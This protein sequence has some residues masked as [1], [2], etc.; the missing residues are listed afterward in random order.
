MG[1]TS[2]GPAVAGASDS[3]G[4]AADDSRVTRDIWLLAGVIVVGAF[5][6]T[7]T[8]TIVN[9]ALGT[10]SAEL[11]ASMNAVQLVATGYLIAL[12][13]AIPLSGWA[14][15]RIGADR[16]WL[17]ALAVFTL[18]SAA[19]AAAGSIHLLIGLR[20]LQGLAG[21]LLVPTGQM[22]L[23]AAA[24]P[25]RMGRVMSIVGIPVVLAPVLGPSLGA[26]LLQH[27][28]WQWLFLVNVPF[29][30]VGL[31]AGTRLLPRSTPQD[32]GRLDVPGTVLV[33]LG[34]PLV[35]YG[36]A[37]IAHLGSFT[38]PA[39]LLP[40]LTGVLLLALFARHELRSAD[41]LLDLRLFRNTAFASA[42]VSTFCL[43]AALF[44]ALIVLPLY[45]LR[46]RH[47]SI[48]TAGLLMAPQ[49]LGTVLALP[50]SGRLTDR[51]GGGPVI[52]AGLAVA[53]LG[54]VPLAVVGSGD[55]LRYLSAVLVLRGFGIGLAT[56][57]A[58][59]TAYSVIE[60]QQIQHA[61]PLLNMLQRVGGSFG[62]AIL[63]VLFQARATRLGAPSAAHLTA[64]FGY[65]HWWVVAV[66]AV[67]AVPTAVLTRA[68]RKHRATTA[69]TAPA[70]A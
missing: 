19:C 5:M 24:G 28:G 8:T 14:A 39:G 66:T 54:T 63:T 32:A 64:A 3:T 34:L 13:A 22:M 9:V 27:L 41:P 1:S 11:T 49:G 20:L 37:E 42:C 45:Y 68:H 12:A 16:L 44:G 52:L 30:L 25:K 46:V 35:T 43:G 57:P 40:T 2:A 33:A 47:E 10:L 23:A 6:S 36:V 69:A 67:A 61:T 18:G 58:M 21:G 70:P 59:S 51:V 26:L 50:L 56:M 55:D 15:K 60:R 53:L 62:T 17:G 7:L 65:T 4:A 48:V 29:G 38:D 31:V